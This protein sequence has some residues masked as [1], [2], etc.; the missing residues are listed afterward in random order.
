M[1]AA[2]RAR[3]D[4][5]G[6]IPFDRF[7]EAALYAPDIGYYER[8][9]APIG[10]R[11]DYL[12]AAHGSRLFAGAFAA[13]LLS[14]WRTRGRPEPLRLAEVGAGDGTLGANLVEAIRR[15]SEPPAAIEYHVIE[16]SSARREEGRRRIE[17]AGAEAQIAHRFGE[18][19][20]FDGSLIAHELLDALPF[21]RL[22]RHGPAWREM[23]VRWQEPEF[24]DS[25]ASESVPV[26]GLEL[27]GD[28]PEGTVLEISPRAEAFLREVADT[29]ARGEAL[30]VDYGAPT[31]YWLGGAHAGTLQALR[32]HHSVPVLE[33]PGM[34]DITAWVNFDRIRAAVRSARLREIAFQPQREALVQWGLPQ[35]LATAQR[36]APTEVDRVRLLMESKSLLLGFGNFHVLEVGPADA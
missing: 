16:R 33:R 5:D 34:A 8:S 15:S 32:A 14:G 2:I 6:F 10:V 23:G 19:A 18:L 17:A 28:A 35:L 3:A 29:I 30:F 21:R 31:S 13:R 11:G 9:E 27:P 24:V 4:P 22:V 7:V 36:E 1:V 26:P 12:T 20:P 25:Q